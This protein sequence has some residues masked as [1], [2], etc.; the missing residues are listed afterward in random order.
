MQYR[1]KPLRGRKQA[2]DL[3]LY[4]MFSWPAGF[5]INWIYRGRVLR[6]A[7]SSTLLVALFYKSLD[8]NGKW[9]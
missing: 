5:A 1:C 4:S 8:K 3:I 2:T 7:F 6:G 9:L